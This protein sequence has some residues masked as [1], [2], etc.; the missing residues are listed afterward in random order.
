M[1]LSAQLISKQ[2]KEIIEE[3]NNTDK[4]AREVQ[5]QVEHGEEVIDSE[6]TSSILHTVFNTINNEF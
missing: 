2:L 1:R 6:N 5:D 4:I 3:E